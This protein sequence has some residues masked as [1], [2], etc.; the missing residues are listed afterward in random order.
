M[1]RIMVNRTQINKHKL[2]IK[3]FIAKIGQLAKSII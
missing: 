2:S 3:G 1:Q